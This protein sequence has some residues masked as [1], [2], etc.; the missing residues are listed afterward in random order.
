GYKEPLLRVISVSPDSPAQK[1]GLVAGD[2][3]IRIKDQVAPL[4]TVQRAERMLSGFENDTVDIVVQ[5]HLTNTID[6]IKLV[7]TPYNQ[8]GNLHFQMIDGI[9]HLRVSNRLSATAFDWIKKTIEDNRPNKGIIL[10]LRGLNNGVDRDGFKLADLFIKDG[11]DIGA[12][13]DANGKIVETVKSEDGYAFE[14]YPLV[15][16]VDSTSAGSAETCA[17]AM[18]T[19]GRGEIIGEKTFGRAIEL[20]RILLNTNYSID[21]ISGVFGMLD[22]SICQ[23]NGLNPDKTVDTTL[24]KPESDPF[25][26]LALQTLNASSLQEVSGGA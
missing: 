14:N 13:C 2:S 5:H 1:A 20:K 15:I 25:I 23:N 17:I 8:T 3:I 6:E 11:L 21:L 9:V 26:D 18:K 12:I 22:G 7:L 19:A 24:T 16:L 4:I 10:D